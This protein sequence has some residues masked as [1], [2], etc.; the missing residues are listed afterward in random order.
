MTATAIEELL[1]QKVSGTVRLMPEGV[2][3][4]RVFTPFKFDD[5]D[6]LGIV[7]RRENADWVLS[8]E[9]S[10]YMHLSY[11]LD[12]KDLTSGAR[13]KIITNAL[14]VF[15]VQD[16]DGEL[17]LPVPDEDYGDALYSFVQALLKITDVEFLSREQ[18]RSAFLADFKLFLTEKVE[19]QRRTFD[20]HDPVLDPESNYAVDCRVNGMARPLFV[21][22]LTGDAKVRDATIALHRFEKWGFQFRAVGIFEDQEEI[23]RKVLARFTDVCERQFSNL[24]GN[25][26]RILA[27]V[28]DAMA[29]SGL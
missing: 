3:R 22:A 7:L 29:A 27:Y 17:T 14:S 9:G 1:K 8:D 20:W 23:G 5:G 21:Y 19:D 13:Q 2:D 11:S 15:S 6:H 12:H 4:F 10:T 25:K 18:V 16:R 26:E 28:T 24:G